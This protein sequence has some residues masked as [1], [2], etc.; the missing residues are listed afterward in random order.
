MYF[1]RQGSVD[2][3]SEKSVSSFTPSIQ[4]FR[5]AMAL[6]PGD[7]AVRGDKAGTEAC[8]PDCW[9]CMLPPI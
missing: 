9:L 4:R 5:K 7:W 1:R 2:L 8:I 6:V 3:Q